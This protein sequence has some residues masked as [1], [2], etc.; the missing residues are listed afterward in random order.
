MVK[1]ENNLLNWLHFLKARTRE[2]FEA[3]AA[4]DPDIREAVNI[5][6]ELSA[7][8]KVRVE[9]NARQKAK[10]DRQSQSDGNLDKAN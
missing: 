3:V 4:T 2:E 8:E 9:Y 7:D 1:D 6:Y 5:L 10:A